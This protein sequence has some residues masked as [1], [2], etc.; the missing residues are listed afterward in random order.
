MPTARRRFMITE[1]DEVAAALSDAAERWPDDRGAPARLLLHLVEEGRAV[2][3][4]QRDR[5]T[6]DDLRAIEETSGALTGVYRPGYLDEV[7]RDW[8]E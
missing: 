1:T 3:A 4:R 7:R 5:R 6:E 8:P 2:V